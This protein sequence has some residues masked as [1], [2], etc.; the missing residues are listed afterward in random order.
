MQ[1]VC[2]LQFAV[3]SLQFADCGL[4]IADCGL[5][6]PVWGL[7][8]VVCG[9]G[10]GFGVWGLGFAVCGW[11]LRFAVCGLRFAVCGL[12]F[13]FEF[14]ILHFASLHFWVWVLVRP[15]VGQMREYIPSGAV[16]ARRSNV[17]GGVL[18]L[19]VYCAMKHPQL[20]LVSRTGREFRLC[21]SQVTGPV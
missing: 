1:S 9:W 7:G 6:I 17:G 12:R 3:C 15:R 4:R 19:V 21:Y 8:F 11:G 2:S 18:H 13:A 10:L 5:R 16:E 14:C 20:L